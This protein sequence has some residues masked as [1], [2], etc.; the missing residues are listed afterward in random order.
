MSALKKN[1]YT[2]IRKAARA[3]NVLN[4]TLRNRMSGRNSYV[5]AHTVEQILLDAEEKTLLR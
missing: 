4:T 1:E 5:E 2:S 3:F